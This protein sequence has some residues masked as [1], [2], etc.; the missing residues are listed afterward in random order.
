MSGLP[1]IFIN[2]LL[3]SLVADNL[4]GIIINDLL[5]LSNFM[6]LSDANL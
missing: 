6:R 4:E 5:I 1:L 2:G 3:G